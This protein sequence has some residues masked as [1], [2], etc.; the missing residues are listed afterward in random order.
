M[1]FENRVEA[2][3]ALGRVLA[4]NRV[5][6][7]ARVFGLPRGGLVVGAE[8]GRELGL[9]LEMIAVAKIGMATYSEIAA[10]AMSEGGVVVWGGPDGMA[11]VAAG[12]VEKAKAKVDGQVRRYRSG[13]PLQ[14][15]AGERAIVVDD[16]LATG[17]T[18]AAAVTVLNRQGVEEVM[19]AAPVGSREAKQLLQELGVEVT[20][21]E[22]FAHGFI[23]RFYRDFA[24]VS[25]REAVTLLGR[26]N[27]SMA[28][29]FLDLI[30]GR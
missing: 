6:G 30:S 4:R 22:E 12:A 29:R 19:V 17:L 13:K 14:L 5:A 15:G 23:G 16:G 27:L 11:K 9:G 24:Q 3:K 26:D 8:V 20:T 2:G 10:G 18:A 28:R 25:E 21:L 7:E 1:K